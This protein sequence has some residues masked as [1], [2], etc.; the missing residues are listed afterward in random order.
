M[1]RIEKGL[2][3]RM[4]RLLTPIEVGLLGRLGDGGRQR[5]PLS[6]GSL[7]IKARCAGGIT[8]PINGVGEGTGRRFPHGRSK[9]LRGASGAGWSPMFNTPPVEAC[10]NFSCRKRP[11]TIS[12]SASTR[13]TASKI[14]SI[15]ALNRSS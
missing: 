7:M 9:V 6:H 1:C 2:R 5:L 14:L 12:A 15:V 13:T 4:T 10:P 8:Q 11:C 3:I